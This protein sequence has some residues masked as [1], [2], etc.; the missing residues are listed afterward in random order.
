MRLMFIV[1]GEDIAVRVNRRLRLSE[2]MQ[3]ALK[4]SY[5]TGRPLPDWQCHSASGVRLD[6]S[7]KISDLVRAGL[8]TGEELPAQ[9]V[10][11]GLSVGAG[12]SIRQ[13]TALTALGPT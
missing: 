8:L 2:I 1:N 4:A 3:K 11:L 12:G 5:N 6:P 13:H 7:R 9:R 10:F